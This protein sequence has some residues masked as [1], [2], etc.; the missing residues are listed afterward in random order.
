MSGKKKTFPCGHRGRGAFCHRCAQE[1]QRRTQAAQAR[2]A[3]RDRLAS[4]PV[5]LDRLPADV[6]D[7]T[8]TVITQLEQG[9]SSMEFGGKRLTAM[10]QRNIVSIPIGLRH[11]LICR[12]EE[13]VFHCLEAISH[14]EYNNRLSAGGWRN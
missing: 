11:R 8:L 9:A 14:E 7:R 13:G 5:P 10:G 6:A 12:E 3:R 2:Q 4:S 1:K